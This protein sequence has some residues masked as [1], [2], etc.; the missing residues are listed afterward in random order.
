VR[1]LAGEALLKLGRLKEAGQWLEETWSDSR[2][3][4]DL[5]LRAMAE[6]MQAKQLRANARAEQAAVHLAAA[7]ELAER[8][9]NP[10][11]ALQVLLMKDQAGEASALAR[12]VGA[13]QMQMEV[14]RQAPYRAFTGEG[15]RPLSLADYQA[16]Q[17]REL[18]FDL[19]IDLPAKKAQERSHGPLNLLGRRILMRILL[20][21]VHARGTPLSQGE[22]F[23]RVWEYEFEGESSAAQVR[24]NISVL[25]D[26]LEPDRTSPVYI[27]QGE[28][29]FQ[30]KGGYYF[31]PEASFCVIEG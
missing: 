23:A 8:L 12:D 5:Q 15:E 29:S 6:L 27:R 14:A 9:Q 3:F 21:L 31:N 24:K 22:L 7:S 25:R 20:A 2:R 10:A 18:D 28:H 30:R 17:E 11:L 26:L 19:W 16:L 4:P 1:F 13:R